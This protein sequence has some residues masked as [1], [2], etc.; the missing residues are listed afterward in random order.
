MT[1]T[2]QATKSQQRQRSLPLTSAVV[3]PVVLLGI[4]DH[5]GRACKDTR[6]RAVGV[7]LGTVHH[8]RV[9]VLNSFAVPFEEDERNPT[10][11]FFDHDYLESMVGMFRKVAARERVVGWYS[12]GPKIRP[13]D[14]EINELVRHYCAE[15]AGDPLFLVCKAEPTSELGLPTEAY[16]SVED[17]SAS[18]GG[19]GDGDGGGG[20]AARVFEHVPNEIGALEAEEVGTEHLL[21]DVKDSSISTLV[22][23]VNAKVH[24][25]KSLKVRLGEI[26]AYLED[27][28]AGRMPV[29]NQIMY[30]MQDIFNLLPNV[31]EN[32][33][34]ARA[35]A[36][37]ANDQMLAVYV[38]SLVRSILALHDLINNK[39]EM[40]ESERKME[41]A[42]AA[43]G[44]AEK[45]HV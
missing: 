34:L 18:A 37:N 17:D 40:M 24:A 29:N 30:E 14:A 36:V 7:L 1:E 4:V 21:R 8:G 42:L 44:D 32:A 13:A 3:H 25:L 12:T 6:K 5:Y 20:G 41:A 2:P 10:V 33:E 16:V 31:T 39:E 45:E 43:G 35:M 28:A 22:G 19:G 11:F 26:K 38:A 9:D 15:G 27:V 23:E